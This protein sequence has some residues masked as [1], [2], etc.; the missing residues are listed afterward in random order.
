MD[1]TQTALTAWFEVGH[2]VT[3]IITGVVLAIP[4][5]LLWEVFRRNTARAE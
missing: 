3:E 1:K 4:F 5:L 2:I